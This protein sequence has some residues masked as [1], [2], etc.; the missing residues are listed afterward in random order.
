M[1]PNVVAILSYRETMAAH[2]QLDRASDLLPP[3]L[4]VSRDGKFTESVRTG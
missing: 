2:W 3:S 4:A 1:F